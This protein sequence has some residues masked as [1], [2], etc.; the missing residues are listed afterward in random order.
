MDLN[1]QWIGLT[2]VEIDANAN[3]RDADAIRVLDHRMIRLDMP[4]NSSSEA[5]AAHMAHCA[6]LSAS[7]AR[8]WGCAT[9]FHEDGLGRLRWSKKSGVYKSAR[10]INFW[11]RNALLGGLD[12]RCAL[13]GLTL[14]PIWGGYSS[15]VGNMLFDLPDACAAAAEIARRGIAASRGEKDRLPVVPSRVHLRRWKDGEGPDASSLAHAECWP[16]IHRAIKAA[17]IGVRRPHPPLQAAGPGPL[18]HDGRGYAVRTTGSGKGG[19]VTA[20]G[21]VIPRV[22]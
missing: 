8:K 2:V 17:K 6:R 3:P 13:S 18:F 21:P 20:A 12:R 15:T 11:S 22:A 14:S 10:T 19:W 16:S 7:L 9:I 1:P 5:F 4:I